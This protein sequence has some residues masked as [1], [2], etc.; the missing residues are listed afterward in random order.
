[1]KNDFFKTQMWF[2]AGIIVSFLGIVLLCWGANDHNDTII[3]VG[4]FFS[5]FGMLAQVFSVLFVDVFEE[6]H[7]TQDHDLDYKIE[8]TRTVLCEYQQENR[9][10]IAKLKQQIEELKENIKNDRSK[11]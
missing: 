2:L 11:N 1:M 9:A 7:K 4:M 5:S 8:R 3:V 10:E 6:R